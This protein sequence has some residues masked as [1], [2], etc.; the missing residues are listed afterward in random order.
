MKKDF[1][2]NEQI[3]P[4]CNWKGEE[5]DLYCHYCGTPLSYNKKRKTIFQNLV[6]EKKEM[7]KCDTCSK[8]FDDLN[9]RECPECGLYLYRITIYKMSAELKKLI[10]CIT[11]VLIL[12]ISSYI[13]I[14]NY[15]KE[16]K[17][18][19]K[20]NND[21]ATCYKEIKDNSS[22]I[23]FKNVVNTHSEESQFEPEAY[24]KLYSAIDERIEKIK[25]GNDDEKLIKMLNNI[26]KD[27]IVYNSSSIL[28]KIEDRYLIAD[29]YSDINKTKKYVE[30]QKYKEAYDLLGKI[31]TN[32]KEKNQDIVDIATNKQNE[33][34]DKA[35]GQI[36][37]MGQEKINAQEYSSAQSLLS[38]YKDLGNQLILDMYNIATN[39][40][41]RIEAE[42]QARKEAEQR[43]REKREAE[44]QARKEAEEKARK[45]SQGVYIGMTQQ[46][47]LDS[48][49][50]KP[51]DINK[52]I[53]AWGVHEQWVYGN[54]NYLYFEDGIL[55]SIQN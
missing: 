23:A 50:G 32:N 52:T 40:V 29:S 33:I 4:K 13:G 42:E 45:K 3:C 48:S 1:K 28:S 10:F 31:I 44:E 38:N 7:M 26:R 8:K 49:W 36:F 19:E 9:L 12:I 39:E 5:G 24:Q 43:E 34:K 25:S 37:A 22:W 18:I 51:K 16:Q 17:R 2:K 27:K 30:E 53:G 15:I 20:Y 21:I 6:I 35:F 11:L 47:V 41:N 54:G 46:D 55:T 14:S